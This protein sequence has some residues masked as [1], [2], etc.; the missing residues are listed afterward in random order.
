[1]NFADAPSLP[2]LTALNLHPLHRRRGA[3]VRR[4][5]VEEALNDLSL[6][7]VPLPGA[8]L[9]DA[10]EIE[11]LLANAGI[12]VELISIAMSSTTWAAKKSQ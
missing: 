1:M 6:A 5:E 10:V 11:R 2:I 12:S 3:L 8:T 9:I 4:G 7:A